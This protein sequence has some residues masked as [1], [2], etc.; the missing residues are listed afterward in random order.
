M[1]QQARSTRLAT[2]LTR[3]SVLWSPAP[4][5]VL[6][7]AAEIEREAD[8]ETDAAPPRFAARVT[9]E[10]PGPVPESLHDYLPS[11]N[12]RMRPAPKTLKDLPGLGPGL[13]WALR[14]A[15]IGSLADL[16]DAQPEALR[17]KMGQIGPLIDIDL[18][19]RLARQSMVR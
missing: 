6:P 15:G 4:G 16:A 19:V 2:D 12:S 14:Q 5:H 7:A 13:R 9:T 8:K 10:K 18:W 17:K 3:Q 1:A 11:R